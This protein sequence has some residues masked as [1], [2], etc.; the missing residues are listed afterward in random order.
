L[1]YYEVY[2]GLTIQFDNVDVAN[3]IV[4]FKISLAIL[5]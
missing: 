3:Y 5:R 4:Q 1:N 2:K